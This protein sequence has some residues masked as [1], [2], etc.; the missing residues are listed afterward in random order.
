MAPRLTLR[1]GDTQA[2][3]ELFADRAP[4]MCRALLEHLPV[5]STAILAKVA[6]SELMVRAPYFYD[7]PAENEVQAQEAGNVCY[8]PFSQNICIFCEDLP[9]LGKVSLIGRITGNLEGVQQ[10]AKRCA[11]RQ[12]EPVEI[13]LRGEGR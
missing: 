8:W 10:A 3:I 11:R 4:N 9:G 6:G 2:G 1:V 5:R 13:Q 7:G 12:G